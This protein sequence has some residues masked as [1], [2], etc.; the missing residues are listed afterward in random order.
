MLDESFGGIGIA[1][2]T[3]V[4]IG[5]EVDIEVAGLRSWAIVRNVKL[6]P[7]GCRLGLEWKAQALSRR[8][9]ELISCGEQLSDLEDELQRLAR[10]LPG[11]LS[12]LWKLFEAGRWPQLVQSAERLKKEAAICNVTELTAPIERL[13]ECLRGPIAAEAGD[14]IDRGAIQDAVNRLID[15]CVEVCVSRVQCVADG[16]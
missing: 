11:G 9:R 3:F 1:M 2:P 7:S 15:K 4:E 5:T 16:R 8:L 6:L 13:Q 14:D 12:M 10:I